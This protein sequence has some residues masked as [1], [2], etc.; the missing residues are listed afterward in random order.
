LFISEGSS[1]KRMNDM[2]GDAENDVSAT[3]ID[4]DMLVVID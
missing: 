4:K 2:I 1:A 3:G